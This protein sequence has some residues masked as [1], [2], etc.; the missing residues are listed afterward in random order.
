MKVVFDTNV[1]ISAFVISASQGERA[2]ILARRRMFDLFTSVPILTETA[3]KLRDK[4]GQTD[5][6]IGAALRLISRIAVIVRPTQRL[7][8]LK[9][10]PD[11]RI[12]ECAAEAA[13]DVVVTG[14]RHI[15]KLKTHGDAAILR[16]GDFLRLFPADTET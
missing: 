5:E 7:H 4:F 6:D 11:N 14:D 3:N 13:A 9:D 2:L 15:L 8:V 16:L 10:D 1:Y 12:L